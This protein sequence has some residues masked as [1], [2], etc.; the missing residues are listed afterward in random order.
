MAEIPK[1]CTWFPTIHEI[2]ESVEIQKSHA[3]DQKRLA[4][5][6]RPADPMPIEELAD[7]AREL[8]LK[9]SRRF[10]YPVAEKPQKSEKPFRKPVSIDELQR[11]KEKLQRQAEQL[12]DVI[13]NG[14]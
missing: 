13:K 3:E 9:L 6:C 1:R 8:V 4:L 5:P 2:L 10:A 14:S 11:R 12:T 7:E